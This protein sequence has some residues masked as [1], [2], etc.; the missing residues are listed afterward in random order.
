MLFACKMRVGY[1]DVGGVAMSDYSELKELWLG[2]ASMFRERMDVLEEK[3]VVLGEKIDNMGHP[4]SPVTSYASIEPSIEPEIKPVESKVVV[5][6]AGC[7]GKTVWVK[8]LLT[9]EFDKKYIPT[10]GVSVHSNIKGLTTVSEDGV[11]RVYNIWDTAGQ[12]HLG[13]L[14]DG[15]YISGNVYKGEIYGVIFIDGSVGSKVSQMEAER[16]YAD[17][18]RVNPGAPVVFVMS[19]MDVCTV[20]NKEIVKRGYLLF[21]GKNGRKQVPV[22]GLNCKAGLMQSGAY[23]VLLA[24]HS[25]N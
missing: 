6:G 7:S 14:R 20:G 11:T 17:F 9:G 18:T 15:Y 21:R 25:I 1:G 4:E 19:K 2:V 5:M 23:D 10:Q 13:G 22:V 3:I 8:M 12:E 16:Y 24:L